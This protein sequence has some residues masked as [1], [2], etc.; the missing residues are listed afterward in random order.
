MGSECLN[1]LLPPKLGPAEANLKWYS[2]EALCASVEATHGRNNFQLSDNVLMPLVSLRNTVS[3]PI[4][5]HYKHLK[6]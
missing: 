3:N 4:S 5:S 1:L 6:K 2:L